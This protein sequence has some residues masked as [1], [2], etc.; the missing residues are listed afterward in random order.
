MGKDF[1]IS[2]FGLSHALHIN[3]LTGVDL[4]LISGVVKGILYR[5]VKRGLCKALTTDFG[6][7]GKRMPE[8]Y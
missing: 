4:S 6:S 1:R 3:T 7:R 5:K 2:P 8:G